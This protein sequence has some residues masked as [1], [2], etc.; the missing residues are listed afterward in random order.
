VSQTIQADAPVVEGI[1]FLPGS[2]YRSLGFFAGSV[3]GLPMLVV[4]LTVG[5]IAAPVAVVVFVAALAVCWFSLAERAWVG[6]EGVW[7]KA[8]PGLRERFVPWQTVEELALPVGS[9][10][11]PWM[12]LTSRERV[13]LPMFVDSE[14]FADAVA[15]FAP[16]VM[17]RTSEVILHTQVPR[18]RWIEGV[19]ICDSHRR[20]W[21]GPC[22]AEAA[23]RP[24]PG[25]ID[26]DL[27]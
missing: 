11:S 21:C 14:R 25:A 22:N 23:H 7:I 8:M 12:W 9:L 10:R 6:P 1:H 5:P 15:I 4:L 17:A 20:K 24:R 2:G 3:L 16:E 13:R 26:I 27:G 18:G 19:W